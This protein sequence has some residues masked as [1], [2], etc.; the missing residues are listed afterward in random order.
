MLLK[1]KVQYG[2]LTLRLKD[3]QVMKKE[4]VR[5]VLVPSVVAS[6]MNEV[7]TYLIIILL[8]PYHTKLMTLFRCMC[9]LSIYMYVCMHVCMH[10]YMHV[11]MFMYV[12]T[13]IRIYWMHAY[14]CI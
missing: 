13:R 5:T 11:C 6:I 3:I 7:S 9:T 1:Y 2:V 4:A 8:I 12:C 14:I 10:V